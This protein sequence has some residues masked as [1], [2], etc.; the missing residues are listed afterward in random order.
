MPHGLRV[1]PAMIA[2]VGPRGLVVLTWDEDDFSSTNR[3]LT[4]FAGPRVLT[5]YVSATHITHYT[6]LRTVCA[7]LGPVPFGAAAQEASITDV[8]LQDVAVHPAHWTTVKGLYR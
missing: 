4:V 2:A 8:W 7:A 5:N 6:L 1:L 3:I